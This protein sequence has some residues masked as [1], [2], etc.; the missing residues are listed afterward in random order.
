MK[1]RENCC[2]DRSEMFSKNSNPRKK[3]FQVPILATKMLKFL[4][5]YP[6]HRA[7]RVHN[8]FII[9]FWYYKFNDNSEYNKLATSHTDCS[10]WDITS[11]S[12]N[13]AEGVFRRKQLERSFSVVKIFV[14]ALYIV[15]KPTS[16]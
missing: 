14:L 15:L 2:A 11:P 7:H 5:R 10:S 13:T 8:R 6:R 1:E 4:N 16:K 12:C 3:E 9:V